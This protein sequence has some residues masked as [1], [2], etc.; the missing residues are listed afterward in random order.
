MTNMKLTS[1]QKMVMYSN[2]K[3]DIL[4]PINQTFFKVWT[5]FILAVG[6]YFLFQLNARMILNTYI[7]RHLPAA[8]FGFCYTI[9][10][11]TIELFAQEL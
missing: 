10:R 6:L 5:L 1:I 4:P 11:E 8:C 7:Y 3:Y 2:Q 9:F